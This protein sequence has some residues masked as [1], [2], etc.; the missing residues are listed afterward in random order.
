MIVLDIETSGLRPD[1]NG[2]LSIGAVDYKTGEE[3]Y[4]ECWLDTSIDQIDMGALAV[5][6]FT[7]EQVTD[8]TRPFAHYICKQ[9]V[10]W[11]APRSD[12]LAGQQVGSFDIPFL[13]RYIGGKEAFERVFSRRSVDLHSVA[14]T[15]FGESMSLDGILK[16][17]GLAPELRPHNAL[18]GARLERDAFKILLAK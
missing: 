17:C 10:D 18:T 14:F 11:A 12:L 15:K 8:Q 6:G 2:L 3:F 7:R 4:A 13:H 5:N 9:F 1:R 16:A